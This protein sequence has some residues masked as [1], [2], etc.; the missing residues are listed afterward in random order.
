MIAWVLPVWSTP[1]DT[2]LQKCGLDAL[3]FVRYL[4]MMIWIFLPITLVVTPGLAPVN[5]LSGKHARTSV[6]DVFAI[7]NIAPGQVASKLWTHWALGVLVVVWVCY[8][9]H[10][11]ALAFVE[12][13]QEYARSQHYRSQSRATTI[14]VGNIPEAFLTEDKLR[15]AFDV[16]PGGVRD[17][18]I[19]RNDSNLTAKLA[20]REKLVTALETAQTKLIAARVSDVAATRGSQG[21]GNLSQRSG[22]A[23]GAVCGKDQGRKS[24]AGPQTMPKT[25]RET[26]RLPLVIR[27]WLPPVPFFGRKVDLIHQLQ[28]TLQTLNQ[29]IASAR[30]RSGSCTPLNNAFVQ[31]NRQVA[32]HM[33]CQSVL[34]GKPHRMTPRIL[35][36]D[37]TDVIWDNLALSWRQR[38]IRVSIGL[39]VSTS[40]IFL[41]AVPVAFT[42]FLANLDVLASNVSWL[43]WLLLWPSSIKSIIQGVL[44]PALLQVLLLLVPTAYRQVMHF[45]GATTGSA[46]ELGV[47]NWHF[48][49]LFAQVSRLLG[50]V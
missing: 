19:N 44:P 37:P 12:A 17:V 31:F 47:Q 42:S 16:F 43:S 14:L 11:E 38:W 6:L 34:H 35:E 30:A 32:A 7:S 27:A 23:L 15:D 2:I 5:R 48:I 33:A 9:V 50:G 18:Y 41:Y 39:S 20:A 10:C 8:V 25:N 4:R 3:F 45:Q 36:V 46:R 22:H 28:E 24:C 1:D 29:E 49:F 26:T 21:S 13:K 40:L